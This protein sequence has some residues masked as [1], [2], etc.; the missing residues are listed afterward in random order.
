[1]VWNLSIGKWQRNLLA[2]FAVA[3]SS[4]FFMTISPIAAGQVLL[5]G[6]AVRAEV[7]EAGA[8]ELPSERP[9]VNAGNLSLEGTW[10]YTI[11][12]GTVRLQATNIVNRR[13]T[14]SGT[15]R[16]E[17][18]ALPTTYSGG[19]FTGY[20]IGQT[21]LG[22][23]PA[24]FQF[25]GVDRTVTQLA[26]PP[27]GTW[28]MYMFVSE[29]DGSSLNDGFSAVDW[30]TF[31]NP[32]WVIGS[33]SLPDFEVSNVFIPVTSALT[34]QRITGISVTVRNSGSATAPAGARVKMY[35]STNDV[36]STSDNFSGSYCDLSAL[37]PGGATTC[38]GFVDTPAAA[39]SYYFGAIINETGA[40]SE[41]NYSNNSGFDPIPVAVNSS[42]APTSSPTPEVRLPVSVNPAQ[43]CPGYYVASVDLKSSASF[44]DR[45]QWGLQMLTTSPDP[46]LL[47][48]L[49]FGGY[50]TDL[51]VPATPGFAAFTVNNVFNAAQRVDFTMRGDGGQYDVTVQSSFPP[52]T[53]RSTVF[54]QRLTLS[55][56]TPTVRSVTLPNGFHIV[57]VQPINGTRVFNVSAIT[58]YLNGSGA[59]FSGG[60]VVGGYLS[61]RQGET[62]F[63][64]LCTAYSQTLPISTFGRATYGIGG[65]GSLRLQVL[66]GISGQLLFD[67]K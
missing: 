3:V 63:A 28:Y 4:L 44:S 56:T 46:V 36:I 52:Y 7:I 54:S 9:K 61:G 14:N 31:S 2:F 45:G 67:S 5:E 12:G 29:F 19:S 8:G 6:G 41:S 16:L 55:A 53:S 25:T 62:G 15:I 1:M 59:A 13:T 33:A 27:N 57:A 47:G 30:E 49:N 51:T 11:S 40:I 39:G 64:A 10:A 38:S 35:W 58:T 24:G 22:T 32:I 50:G 66:D 18:W 23:L 21:T 65:A 42:T 43:A 26:T 17:L 48:G 34:N 20:K 37:A 60:A